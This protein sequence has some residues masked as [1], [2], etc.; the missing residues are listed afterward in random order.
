METILDLLDYANIERIW[1]ERIEENVRDERR[2]R[3]ESALTSTSFAGPPA[4]RTMRTRS[5]I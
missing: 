3:A 2:E 4:T 1:I 5:T